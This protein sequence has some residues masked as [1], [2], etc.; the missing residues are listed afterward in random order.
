[1]DC[2]IDILLH[3]KVIDPLDVPTKSIRNLTV[4][5]TPRNSL[6]FSIESGSKNGADA[7]GVFINKVDCFLRIDNKSFS[8]AINISFLDIKVT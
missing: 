1:M 3:Q 6:V 4:L 7:N 5:P 2:Y 8:R